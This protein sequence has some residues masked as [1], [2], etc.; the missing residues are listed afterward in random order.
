MTIKTI[1]QRIRGKDDPP[2]KG[3]ENYYV[4]GALN[5]VN[6]L[7]SSIPSVKIKINKYHAVHCMTL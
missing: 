7:T 5:I 3:T 1:T 4:K 6:L 2:S